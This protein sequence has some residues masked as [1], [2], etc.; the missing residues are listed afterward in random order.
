MGQIIF[1][2]VRFVRQKV[3]RNIFRI[4]GVDIPFDPA[5]YLVGSLGSHDRERVT[6]APHQ[7]NDYNLEQVLADGFIVL[8]LVLRF[9]KHRIEIKQQF[10]PL[11]PIIDNLVIQASASIPKIKAHPLNAEHDI[12]QRIAADRNL[13]MLHIRVYDDKIILLYRINVVLD[14]EIPLTAAD[15]K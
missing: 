5:A 1:A 11:I 12:L 9:P 10:V 13:G 14:N 4:V 8:F 15:I 7:A 3:E 2:D 6:G